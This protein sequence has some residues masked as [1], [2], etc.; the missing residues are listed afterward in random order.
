MDGND[1]IAY[2]LL[3]SIKKL[4][5]HSIGNIVVGSHLMAVESRQVGLASLIDPSGGHLK[6]IPP[7]NA[8]KAF[9]GKSAKRVA[10]QLLEDNRF[11]SGVGLASITSLYDYEKYD[12][13][14]VKAQDILVEKGRGK[15]VAVIG[16]FP[17]VD[18]IR[19]EFKKLWVIELK[20]RDGDVDTTTGFEVLPGCDVVAITATTIIN[21]TLAGI[22]SACKPG[23]FRILLGPSTPMNPVLFEFGLTM[24]AGSMV[25]DRE[26][27]FCGISRGEAFRGLQ[28]IDTVCLKR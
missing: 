2:A 23:S 25:K 18:R 9:E 8:W 13:I 27:V 26:K 16:H 7:E 12:F 19:K 11:Y 28:G 17:F 6:D 15:E 10:N 21:K 14:K 5:D 20:P 22:L 24:L 3:E 4:D 1:E